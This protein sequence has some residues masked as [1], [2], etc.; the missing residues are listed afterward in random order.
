MFLPENH[1]GSRRSPRRGPAPSIVDDGVFVTR[2]ALERL[3]LHHPCSNYHDALR[4][5]GAAQEMEAGLAA[6]FLGRSLA[7]VQD[8]YWMASDRRGIFVVVRNRTQGSFPWVLITY[9]RFGPYQQAVAVRLFGA[10]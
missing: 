2:H 1:S 7:G 4:L 10:A 3:Q 5:L 8:R 9:L 6:P